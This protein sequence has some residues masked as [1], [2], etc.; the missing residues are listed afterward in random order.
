MTPLCSHFIITYKSPENK[1]SY[2]IFLHLCNT[3]NNL[4]EKCSYCRPMRPNKMCACT[5]EQRSYVNRKNRTAL[6]QSGPE[7]LKFPSTQCTTREG[8]VRVLSFVVR[9]TLLKKGKEDIC[10][11]STHGKRTGS[12]L[13]VLYSN[14]VLDGVRAYMGFTSSFSWSA[15]FYSLNVFRLHKTA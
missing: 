10:H 4:N 11:W 2:H 8:M 5:L 14:S 3:C 1:Y 6:T 7:R 9:V 12:L 15:M 13:R